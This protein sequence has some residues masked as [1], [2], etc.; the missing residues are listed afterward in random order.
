MARIEVSQFLT[1]QTCRFLAILLPSLTL[2]T[3]T[4]LALSFVL[5]GADLDRAVFSV[6]Y[7]VLAGTASIFGIIGAVRVSKPSG[8]NDV[9][10]G[11]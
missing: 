6:A 11:R 7:N 8:K 2:C 9:K 1:S 10:F 4:L 3:H 5:P